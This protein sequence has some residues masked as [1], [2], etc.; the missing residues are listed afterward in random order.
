MTDLPLLVGVGI[1]TP[2]TGARRARSR[3]AW[4][5]AARSW[6]R[7]VAGDLDGPSPW[8]QAFRDAIPVLLRHPRRPGGGRMTW[9]G[10]SR[11]LANRGRDVIVTL[12]SMRETEKKGGFMKHRRWFKAFASGRHPVR[13]GGGMCQRRRGGQ[14]GERRA[15][16]IV[17]PTSSVRRG[18]RGRADQ[19]RHAAGDRGAD[20]DARPGQPERRSSWRWTTSTARSTA[21]TGSS[22]G[23]RRRARRTRTTVLRRRRAGRATELAADPSIVAVI[24]TSCSSAA[25]GV[26]DKIL[27]GQG[28][29]ADLA[30]EHEPGLTDRGDAPARSTPAPRTTTASRRP[31]VAEFAL[32]ESGAKTAATIHDESP[33]TQGLTGG[34][35][36]EL[37]GRRRHGHAEE[38]INSADTDFKPLLTSIAAGR[39]RTCCTSRTSSRPAR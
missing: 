37:R 21:R 30:V 1:G 13:R 19:D 34:V 10:R 33:Y 9:W 38:A 26:A 3:T 2:R 24:G 31:I 18:R 27:V 23:P 12:E 36:G 8:R 11:G 7:V 32:Q 29:P 22:L 35:R 5:W 39:S 4:S 14:H 25:L 16:S 17:R 20:A 15:A 28:H 6:R